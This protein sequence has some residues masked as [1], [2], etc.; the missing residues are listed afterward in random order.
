M[1][2]GPAV[3]YVTN[4]VVLAESGSGNDDDL[5]H[6]DNLPRPWVRVDRSASSGA[7]W[8]AVMEGRVW[9]RVNNWGPSTRQVTAELRAHPWDSPEDVTLLVK[10]Q[11][12]GG[13]RVVD[14]RDPEADY[15]TGR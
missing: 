2:R 5:T 4:Y 9:L 14:W 10:E 13:W 11:D 12:F 15:D 8:G 3:S 7:A 1:R 6:P